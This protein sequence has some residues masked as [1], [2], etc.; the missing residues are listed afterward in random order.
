MT[1]HTGD[2]TT[3]GSTR[4]RFL[5]GAAAATTGALAIGGFGGTAAAGDLTSQPE[6]PS[7]Y[8]VVSTR[9]HFNS[10]AEVI[11]GNNAWNYDIE[12][13]WDNYYTDG[14]ELVVFVHG[15][16]NGDEE[17][18]LLPQAVGGAYETDLALQQNGYD[19]TVACF[20][21]DSDEGRSLDLG[22][23]DAKDI[24]RRNGRKLATFIHY[25]NNG[26]YV[27]VSGGGPVRIVAHSLGARVV[28]EALTSLRYDFGD[29]NAVETVS[30]LGGAIDEDE[31]ALGG[32]YGYDIEYA[33][34]RLDNYYNWDDQILGAIYETRELEAAVGEEALTGWEPDNYEDRNVSWTVDT[35]FD[36]YQRDIGCIP[37]VVSNF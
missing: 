27:P 23:A 26:E 17:A 5:R 19:E 15:F 6:A 24:A 11:N 37:R 36:Y 33:T 21:W 29:Y 20:S 32:G 35:H 28:G 30:L 1:G 7:D 12:G 8:P 4:R 14:N 3:G 9:D 16:L 2:N 25:W 34:R 31:P 18:M 22:W 10:D 13:T